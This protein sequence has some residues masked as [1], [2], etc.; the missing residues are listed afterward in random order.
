MFDLFDDMQSFGAARHHRPDISP[1]EFEY[2]QPL[3]NIR[4]ADAAIKA[5]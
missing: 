5:K 4:P 3:Q 1:K 2:Q